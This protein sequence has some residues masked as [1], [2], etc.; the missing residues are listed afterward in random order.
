MNSSNS[1]PLYAID[2]V[3]GAIVELEGTCDPDLIEASQA[4]ID[5]LANAVANLGPPDQVTIIDDDS[6][7]VRWSRLE[8]HPAQ[9]T[10]RVITEGSEELDFYTDPY[11]TNDPGDEPGN[12]EPSYWDYFTEPE[13]PFYERALAGALLPVAVLVAMAPVACS[14]GSPGKSN[15]RQEEDGWNPSRLGMRNPSSISQT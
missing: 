7:V 4:N 14:G 6:L 15:P 12:A 10:A 3:H 9:I 2:P 8:R 1:S 13:I 5:P 11:T